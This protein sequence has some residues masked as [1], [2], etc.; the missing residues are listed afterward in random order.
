[1]ASDG[2]TDDLGEMDGASGE[3]IEDSLPPPEVLAKASM[4][5][6][7][8]LADG[9]EETVAYHHSGDVQAIK[10]DES[11]NIK[12]EYADGRYISAH[13]ADNVEIDRNL[14]K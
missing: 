14:G 7:R 4:R 9:T 10:L 3:I 5:V 2:Y 13:L 8:T 12:L 11:G 1:M 6:F